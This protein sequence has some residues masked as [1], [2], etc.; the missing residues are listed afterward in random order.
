MTTEPVGLTNPQWE[1]GDR[2]RKVRRDIAG[3]SQNAMADALGVSQKVY[4]AWESNRSRPSDIVAT[5]KTIAAIW[6]G[7]VTSSWLLGV[8]DPGPPQSPFPS[9]SRPSRTFGPNV[10]GKR[11][12]HASTAAYKPDGQHID[13]PDAA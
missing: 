12:G 5:A 9:P 3:L 8:D 7:D 4:A 6:A 11:I 1:F 10:R 13:L 2:I